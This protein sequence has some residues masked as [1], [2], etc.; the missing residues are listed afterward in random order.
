MAADKSGSVRIAV[1]E[2]Q[3]A[4]RMTFVR[5][6]ELLGY[7]VVCSASNG[8]ELIDQCREQEVDMAF[9]DLDMPVMDGLT[10][11]S[12]LSEQSI[13]VVLISGHPD[14]RRRRCGVRACGRPDRRNPRPWPS[15]IA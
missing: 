12:E 11:A 10:T 7:Q 14:A 8:A 1:A 15:C 9:V 6:L 4:V 3:P 13:P 5:L 2:D